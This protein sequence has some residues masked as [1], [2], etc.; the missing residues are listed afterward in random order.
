[1][2]ILPQRDEVS[3]LHRKNYP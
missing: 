1:M 3:K 2:S